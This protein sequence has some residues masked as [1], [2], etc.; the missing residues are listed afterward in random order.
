MKLFDLQRLTKAFG[1][2]MKGLKE[3]FQNETAFQQELV[4]LLALTPVIFLF[5]ISGLER[6]LLIVSLLF[7]LI[8]E[9][10]NTAI[11]AIVN[12]VSPEPNNLAGYAK[13]LGSAAVLL[14]VILG[15]FVWAGIL[16]NRYLF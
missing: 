4:L 10:L 13:D 15:I 9:V 3:A 2:S 6:I 12:L 7:V 16:G 5:D 1:Y 11:E 8:V 14:S